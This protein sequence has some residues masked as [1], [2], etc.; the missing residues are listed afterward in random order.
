MALIKFIWKIWLRLNLL[1]KDVDNDYNAMVSTAGKTLRTADLAHLVVKDRTEYQEKT[2]LNIAQ[3]I[4]CKIV[5]MLQQGYSVLTGV[6]HISPRV[7]GSWIGANAKFNPEIHKI[8]VDMVP[9]SELRAALKDVG[10]EMLGVKDDG[11]FIG[12]VTDTF[13]N[14]ADGTIT[15]NDDI[16]IEGDKLKIAPDDETG[17]GVFFV[18]ADGDVIPVT[19]RLT[20][21]DPKSI[22]ARVPALPSG[23]YTLRVMT[24]FAGSAHLLKEPRK[25]EYDRLL[26][27]P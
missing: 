13:T 6:C 8:T 2:V 21:N 25:I 24:R 4:D 27:V 15:P 14:L 1:T 11:A 20:Q 17:L 12:L 18:N 19:R 26:I 23:Q 10:L 5:E 9:S 22:L 16:L 7:S 3:L